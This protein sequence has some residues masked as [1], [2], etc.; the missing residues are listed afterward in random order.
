MMATV[1][2]VT[3]GSGQKISGQWIFVRLSVHDEANGLFSR[4]CERAKYVCYP[5]RYSA[6][7]SLI[8]LFNDITLLIA[9][10]KAEKTRLTSNIPYDMHDPPPRWHSSWTFD[11]C[12][13]HSVL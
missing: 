4:I 6:I 12:R 13:R 9:I 11:P 2:H 3:S 5:P 7:W 10:N 8:D 1:P